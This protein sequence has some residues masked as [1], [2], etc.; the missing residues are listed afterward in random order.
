MAPG[1]RFGSYPRGRDVLMI[2]RAHETCREL[3][4]RVRDDLVHFGLVDDTRTTGLRDGARAGAG[5]I[6]VA[7]RNARYGR[8]STRRSP[9]APTATKPSCSPS[10]PARRT[11][12]PGPGQRRNSPGTSG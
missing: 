7:R 9:A 3:S 8:G 1:S 12:P 11:R 4:R 2:A 6:I 10:R 5:D